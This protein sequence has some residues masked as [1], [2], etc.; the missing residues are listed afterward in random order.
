VAGETT[1]CD[2]HLTMKEEANRGQ[3][4]LSVFIQYTGSQCL[5][6]QSSEGIRSYFKKAVARR[7]LGLDLLDAEAYRITKTEALSDLREYVLEMG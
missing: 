5:P 3:R 6:G 1:E 2:Q 4:V 7:P